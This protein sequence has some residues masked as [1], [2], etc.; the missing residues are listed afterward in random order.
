VQVLASILGGVGAG[1]IRVRTG[2]VWGLILVHAVNDYAMFVTRDEINV[3]QAQSTFY[4]VGKIL[5]TV[6]SLAYG[7]YL[8]RDQLPFGRKKVVSAA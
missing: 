4:L 6:I 5:F 7:L 8:M 3:T 1:A 2:T